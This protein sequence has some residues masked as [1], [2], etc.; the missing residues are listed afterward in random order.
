ML[1]VAKI[2]DF[3]NDNYNF[4][5]C[6]DFD[7]KILIVIFSDDLTSELELEIEYETTTEEVVDIIK[8]KLD[9]LQN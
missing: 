1:K 5:I 8:T 2:I 9:E 7:D 6:V 4:N 3:V